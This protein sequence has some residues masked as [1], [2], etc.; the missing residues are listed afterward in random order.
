MSTSSVRNEVSDDVR[1]ALYGD[2]LSMS[3]NMKL[4]Q[5][6]LQGDGRKV[7]CFRTQTVEELVQAVYKA[8]NDYCPEKIENNF[9]TLQK[10]MQ[11]SMRVSGGNNY[12]LPHMKKE[13]RK[14]ERNPIT[15]VVCDEAIH[16]LAL[17][18]L[19]DLER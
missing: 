16:N 10:Y 12:K 14:R 9:I 17:T 2:L 18:T 19:K 11:S 13:M 6:V 15:K 4:P 7:R 5:G 1:F 8:Y 3:D